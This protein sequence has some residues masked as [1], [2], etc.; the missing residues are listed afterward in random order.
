MKLHISDIRK[1]DWLAEALPADFLSNENKY[2]C[3]YYESGI[4]KNEYIIK[5][6]EC[7]YTINEEIY[8][9]LEKFEANN[10]GILKAP[11]YDTQN[12]MLYAFFMTRLREHYEELFP[13]K[14]QEYKQRLLQLWMGFMAEDIKEYEKNPLSNTGIYNIMNRSDYERAMIYF[15]GDTEAVNEILKISDLLE[16]YFTKRYSQEFYREKLSRIV[17]AIDAVPSGLMN[18]NGGK[19]RY[20]IIGERSGLAANDETLAQAKEMLRSGADRDYIML[21]TGWWHNPHDMKW[22]KRIE[23]EQA[24]MIGIDEL[25][26]INFGKIPLRVPEYI[27][28]FDDEQQ[29]LYYDFFFNSYL[30]SEVIQ[31]SYLPLHEVLR[32]DK[33]YEHYPHLYK[34]PLIFGVFGPNV[35]MQSNYHFSDEPAHIVIKAPMISEDML[36]TI[37]HE[38][39]HAI[40]HAE[41]FANGGNQTL[42]TIIQAY[43]GRQVREFVHSYHELRKVICRRMPQITLNEY[44]DLIVKLRDLHDDDQNR[45]HNLIDNLKRYDTTDKLINN[46]TVI[47]DIIMVALM[48]IKSDSGE[49]GMKTLTSYMRD[50]FGDGFINIWTKI[51]EL[52]TAA[53]QYQQELSRKG[54]NDLDLKML[55]FQYYYGLMGEMESR[56]VESVDYEG[57]LRKYFKYYTF[58]SVEQEYQ[59]V[60]Y[61]DM[62]QENQKFPVAGIERDN[63]ERYVMHLKKDEMSV[64]LEA[65]LHE[66]GHIVYDE[67]DNYPQMNEVTDSWLGVDNKPFFND[68]YEEYFVELFICYLVRK[69][70]GV[71]VYDTIR[72]KRTL[73]HVDVADKL[74]IEM[75]TN[76][77]G[78]MPVDKIMQM[79]KFLELMSE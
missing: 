68:N 1:I 18:D 27:G 6:Y 44:N 32:H 63:D 42:G 4:L 65:V 9:N 62:P 47:F 60:Y 76:T 45:Y 67:A 26:E 77:T 75:F 3:F 51:D 21:K 37:K 35:P 71:K 8:R 40:Q 34:L 11:Y 41:G 12:G 23:D 36:S 22:R 46:C 24:S 2:F 15:V 52:I 78:H 14:Y 69:N 16:T 59:S 73:L 38:V 19:M 49:Q 48:T 72:P 58:D 31:R 74:F 33:L 70:E 66:L 53:Q 5:N 13:E 50:A 61:P 56:E 25:I 10:V 57:E 29:K 30:S 79:M 7:Y 28:G 64:N 54:W 39:Q 17:Q 43:G 20:M 55:L